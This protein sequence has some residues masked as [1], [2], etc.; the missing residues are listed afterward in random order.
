MA[1]CAANGETFVDKKGLKSLFT[2]FMGKVKSKKGEQGGA[3]MEHV[4]SI[5]VQL[6][7]S[8]SDVRYYRL[9]RKFQENGYEK[10]ERLIELFDEL[11]VGPL[12]SPS[13]Y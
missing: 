11:Y 7:C 1:N 2:L 4:V 10:V 9:L 5:I 12:P 8:L 3:Q 13:S 6:F